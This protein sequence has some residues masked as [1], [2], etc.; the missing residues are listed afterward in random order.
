MRLQSEC[1]SVA[2]DGRNRAVRGRSVVGRASTAVLPGPA[3]GGHRRLQLGCP[4][5]PFRE[6]LPV[7][8]AGREE[9][10]RESAARSTRKCHKGPERRHRPTG[11][12]SRGSGQQRTDQTRHASER[13]GTHAAIHHQQDTHRGEDRRAPP[14]DCGGCS[15]TSRIGRSFRHRSLRCPKSRSRAAR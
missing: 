4:T 15:S 12:Y 9:P 2:V 3:A 14:L 7:S 6:L 5:N 13:C 10:P 11:D 1:Y 8:R